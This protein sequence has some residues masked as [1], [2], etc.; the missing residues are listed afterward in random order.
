MTV[1]GVRD[2]DTRKIRS[3]FFLFRQIIELDGRGFVQ[4]AVLRKACGPNRDES[5]L[6]IG[7]AT[8]STPQ[9]KMINRLPTASRRLIVFPP[10]G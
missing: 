8:I 3:R 2:P 1:A 10:P 6:P 4:L 9:A 5:Q 7:A